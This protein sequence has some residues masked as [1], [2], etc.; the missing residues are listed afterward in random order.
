[1]AAAATQYKDG[2]HLQ[3]GSAGVACFFAQG[4]VHWVETT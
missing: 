4:T 1:M 3:L 2:L